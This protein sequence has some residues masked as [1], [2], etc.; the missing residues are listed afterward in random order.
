MANYKWPEPKP[1]P[2]PEPK[3][4][5]KP[6]PE[7][8]PEIEPEPQSLIGG[9]L[10][11]FPNFAHQIKSLGLSN[12]ELTPDELAVLK[13]QLD[14]IDYEVDRVRDILRKNA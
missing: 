7:P 13:E 10:E 11:E 4:K 6:E 14:Q 12:L 2:E 3:P 1:K 5:P 9:H 8:E